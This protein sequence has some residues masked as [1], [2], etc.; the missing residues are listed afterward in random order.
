MG[1]VIRVRFSRDRVKTGSRLAVGRRPACGR[2]PAAGPG[3]GAGPPAPG[4]PAQQPSRRVGL[5]SVGQRRRT[6]TSQHPDSARA[7]TLTESQQAQPGWAGHS[8]A[9]P[10]GKKNGHAASRSTARIK[11]G[12]YVPLRSTSQ[13]RAPTKLRCLVQYQKPPKFGIRRRVSGHCLF[14]L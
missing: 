10:V 1:H 3:R 7:A 6:C 13:L 9:T 4:G 5:G 11:P 12:D 2:R 8:N 14:K